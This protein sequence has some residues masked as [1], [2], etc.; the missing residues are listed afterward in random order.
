MLNSDIV[1]CTLKSSKIC[2]ISF[3]RTLP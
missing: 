3:T 2:T 1:T